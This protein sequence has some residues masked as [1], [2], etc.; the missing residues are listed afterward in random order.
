MNIC[1]ILVLEI[2]FTE[3]LQMCTTLSY[4]YNKISL[5]NK[6]FFNWF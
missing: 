6:G 2:N 4:Q 3:K 1:G 5:K